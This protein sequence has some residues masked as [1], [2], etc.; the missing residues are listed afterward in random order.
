[1]RKRLVSG[2]ATLLCL[3]IAVP[4]S[5]QA[6]VKNKKVKP[7]E[8]SIVSVT[9]AWA[10]GSS[11]QDVTVTIS[12]PTS[13]GSG[14]ISGSKVTAGT[15]SCRMNG[16]E[17][18]CVIRSVKV[19]KPIILFASTR[20]EYGSGKSSIGFTY[21]MPSERQ[22]NAVKKA[23]SNLNR[24]GY[25]RSGL[26]SQLQSEGFSL[27]EATYGV[28]SISIDWTA[29]SVKAAG[30]RLAKKPFSRSGLISQ[31]QSE[32]F[33][34]EDATYSVDYLLVDWKLQA[35]KIARTYLRTN[36]FTHSSLISR[37]E[38]DGFST[39]EATYAAMRNGLN[40]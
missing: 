28:D 32:G 13:S 24:N 20:N 3:F 8:P 11:T 14:S 4:P 2:F 30:K 15:K 9:S 37:L 16:L 22:G 7:S 38:Q 19:G 21:E 18:T 6:V 17:T 34:V 29:Q 39:E 1:M 5:A 26:I 31:L 35:A 27:A 25:S 33:S 10:S 40:P 23:R 12:L 36:P